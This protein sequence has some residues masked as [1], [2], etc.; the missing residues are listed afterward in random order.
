MVKATCTV[1]KKGIGKKK[2]IISDALSVLYTQCA[3]LSV[4]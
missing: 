3:S 4:L 2:I 1:E